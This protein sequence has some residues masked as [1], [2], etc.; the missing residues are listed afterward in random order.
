[1][2]TTPGRL[3]Q[4]GGAR[5]ATLHELRGRTT[6]CGIRRHGGLHGRGGCRRRR[7]QWSKHG[8]PVMLRL[9]RRPVGPTALLFSPQRGRESSSSRTCKKAAAMALND[10]RAAK[11]LLISARINARDVGAPGN[12]F[13]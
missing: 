13:R 1:M 7:S 2:R 3:L 9:T 4:V 6:T 10:V 5:A 11:E 12:E 8:P